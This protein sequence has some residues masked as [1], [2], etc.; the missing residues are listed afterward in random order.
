MAPIRLQSP[1]RDANTC[2]HC[3]RLD[4]RRKMLNSDCEKGTDSRLF[5]INK[6][7]NTMGRQQGLRTMW[8]TEVRQSER[9]VQATPHLNSA[10]LIQ[11]SRPQRRQR[12]VLTLTLCHFMLL[13]IRI[14][15][16]LLP[17]ILPSARKTSSKECSEVTQS[18][19]HRQPLSLF[20][21]ILRCPPSQIR[22]E[23]CFSTSS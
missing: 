10:T 18:C 20:H 19:R 22:K 9:G 3:I 2:S 11:P 13:R 23:I 4:I 7:R 21:T 17:P 16:H 14:P 8:S 6:N 5:L 15:M 1:R 12:Y